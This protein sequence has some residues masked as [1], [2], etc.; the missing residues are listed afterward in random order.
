MA[1]PDKG[2]A[3]PTARDLAGSAVDLNGYAVLFQQLARQADKD[4]KVQVSAAKLIAISEFMEKVVD[5]LLALIPP[6][7]VDDAANR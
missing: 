7:D 5:E 4:G 2:T 1:N 3:R 6:D